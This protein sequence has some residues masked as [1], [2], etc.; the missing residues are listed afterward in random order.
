MHADLGL[1]DRLILA[2]RELDQALVFDPMFAP[3]LTARL[4]VARQM[5]DAQRAAQL[6]R[7][8]AP[9]GVR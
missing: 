7:M 9:T 4:Q 6:E 1:K 3:L 8:L 2:A 5:G